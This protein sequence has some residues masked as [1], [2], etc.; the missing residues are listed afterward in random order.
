MSPGVLPRAD[1]AELVL[2]YVGCGSGIYC[3]TGSRVHQPGIPDGRWVNSRDGDPDTLQYVLPGKR[4]QAYFAD[5][6][7]LPVHYGR[8]G[9][10]EDSC[11]RG[12][13]ECG[14]DC[15]VVRRPLACHGDDVR[16]I[17]LH[18]PFPPDNRT[19]RSEY[20][21][22]HGFE[23]PFPVV[24]DEI[25]SVPLVAFRGP[26]QFHRITVGVVA[27]EGEAR[28]G[29]RVRIHHPEGI[30]KTAFVKYCGAIPRYDC[31]I[32]VPKGGCLLS[33]VQMR[34]LVEIPC[35]NHVDA[36]VDVGSAESDEIPDSVVPSG[37]PV[38]FQNL[39]H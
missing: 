8:D 39:L 4:L 6:V 23:G 18:G 13:L 26:G 20:L 33:P 30:L 10:S 5:D 19:C 25:D 16:K 27:R 7:V 36:L 17:L 24:I 11:H 28:G 31:S 15:L 2:K 1:S 21:A 22:V 37:S 34:R 14:E 29:H 38:H 12:E 32:V 35:Q 3:R 9:G